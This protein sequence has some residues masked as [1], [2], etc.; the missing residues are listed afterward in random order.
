MDS[1]DRFDLTKLPSQDALFSKLSGLGIYTRKS[2]VDCLWMYDNG[3]LPRHL[4]AIG[5]VAPC[6]LFLKSFVQP[7]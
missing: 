3:G 7:V 1:F 5:C 6:R 2:S 4:L